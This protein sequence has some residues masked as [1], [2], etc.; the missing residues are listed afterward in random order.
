M[1][2][3]VDDHRAALLLIKVESHD[4]EHSQERGCQQHCSLELVERSHWS[5]SKWLGYEVT[6]LH[7]SE[8]YCLY[9][10]IVNQQSM[11]AAEEKRK[12][13]PFKGFDEDCLH[14]SLLWV[15]KEVLH[16]LSVVEGEEEESSHWEDDHDE[17]EVD[18][19]HV[20]YLVSKVDAEEVSALSE[21]VESELL[22]VSLIDNEEEDAIEGVLPDVLRYAVVEEESEDAGKDEVSGKGKGK[23]EEEEVKVVGEEPQTILIPF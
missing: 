17:E 2:N 10:K 22:D 5:Q 21:E 11:D 23:L 3:K 15:L 4:E 16:Q 18:H 8:S 9:Q 13:R 1:M 19:D 7:Y 6:Q 20:R 14:V 12:D